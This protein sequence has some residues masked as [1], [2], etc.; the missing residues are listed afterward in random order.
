[1]VRHGFNGSVWFCSVFVVKVRFMGLYWYWIDLVIDLGIGSVRDR[2]VVMVDRMVLSI[3]SMLVNMMNVLGLV[4]RW[5][6]RG[7]RGLG[8]SQQVGFMVS[9][10]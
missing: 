7:V 9:V 2:A 8:Y 4:L 3:L 1:M 5:E 10:N 6:I